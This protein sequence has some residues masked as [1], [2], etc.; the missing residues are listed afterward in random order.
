MILNTITNRIKTSEV[1]KQFPFLFESNNS[2][3]YYDPGFFSF[4]DDTANFYKFLI[5]GSLEL[6]LNRSEKKVFL[7]KLENKQLPI[8]SIYSSLSDT[9]IDFYCKSLKESAILFISLDKI[10]AYSLDYEEFRKSFIKSKEY[11]YSSILHVIHSYTTD[12]LEKRLHNYL[13]IKS[14]SYNTLELPISQ[15]EISEELNCSREAVTRNLKKLKTKGLIENKRG[16]IL[17]K[18]E[19]I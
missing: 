6:Y 17:I 12:C 10:R 1:F 5:Y 16:L 4:S 15:N 19:S 8:V 9:P 18:K 2:I 13:L 11:H 14:N 3:K 7:Y